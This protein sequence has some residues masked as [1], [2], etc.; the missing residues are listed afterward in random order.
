M[1]TGVISLVNDYGGLVVG[2]ILLLLAVSVLPGR[3]K[4]YVLTAGLAVLGYEVYLRTVNRKMLKEADAERERLRGELAQ[5]DSR[6]KELESTV[7][8]LNKKLIELNS[9]KGELDKQR[10]ALQAQGDDLSERKQMLDRETDRLVG[11]SKQ[12]IEQ[13]GNS[14]AILAKLTQAQHTIDQMEKIAQ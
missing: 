12:L 11:E 9:R 10:E 7:G 14:E 2:V 1:D 3:I 6:R 13:M 5:L 8:E 4:W